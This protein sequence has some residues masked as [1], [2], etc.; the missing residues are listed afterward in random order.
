[1]QPPNFKFG[2]V[3]NEQDLNV[4]R[5]SYS[6]I[7]NVEKTSDSERLIIAPSS[8]QIDLI[9][10]LSRILPEP[11]G[12]LYILTVPRGGNEE[13]RYQS[14]APA[15]RAVMESF[16]NNFRDFFENDARH[17]IWI[18]S[19]PSNAMLVYDKHNVIYAYGEIENFKPILLA[20][21]LTQGDVSFPVPHVHSY[22]PKFDAEETRIL[23]YAEWKKF[24]LA[25]NDE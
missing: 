22:N 6:N 4:K 20:K 24:P 15:S 11:F 8:G 1:M 13:G 23:S 14:S 7:W 17:H 16:L 9:I 5:F 18:A 12:I 21:G 3:E 25:E 2:T 10:E 19:L